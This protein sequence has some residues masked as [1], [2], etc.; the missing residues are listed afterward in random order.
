[1]IDPI[2]IKS[3]S[4]RI[5][6]DCG[7]RICDWLPHLDVCEPRSQEAII[8]RALVMLGMLQIY[9]K[10]PTKLIR[11]WIAK[12]KAE[13]HLSF[14]EREILN[15]ANESLSQQELTNLYWYIE[16]IWALMWVGKLIDELPYDHPVSNSMASLCPAI[17]LGEDCSK[18]S[19]KMRVR[20]FDEL[21]RQLDL[22]YRLHCMHATRR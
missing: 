9:F 11:E 2:A 1:M 15:R 21:F 16:G 17:H 8:G 20:P 19:S 6:L 12:V 13:S 5:I 7:G 3:E 10:A 14:Q 4:E 18:F 22:Y